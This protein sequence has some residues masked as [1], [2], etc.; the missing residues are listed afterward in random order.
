[1]DVSVI[2]VSYNTCDLLK[3]CICSILEKTKGVSFEIIVVDNH[4]SDESVKVITESF[5][6]VKIISLEENLG[7]G[8]AN[9]WGSYKSI[10]KYLFFLNPDTILL[11]DAISILVEFLSKNPEIAI[12][13]GNLYKEDMS[14]NG[15]YRMEMP[16]FFDEIKGVL[17]YNNNN[18]ECFNLSNQPKEVQYVCGADMMIKKKVFE[19]I[20]GFN[21]NFFMYCEEPFI[22][23]E[24]RKLGYKTYSCPKAKIIHKDGSSCK[25]NQFDKIT[26]F[27]SVESHLKFSRY[28]MGYFKYFILKMMHVLKSSIALIKALFINDSRR[29][30][31]WKKYLY[32]VLHS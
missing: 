6:E 28:Y 11:N 7:F 24:A 27:Y 32:V 18:C 26:R 13:G 22:S 15:S 10:G 23:N 17:N 21:P 2:I 3:K 29:I 16:S 20:G 25:N 8:R 12:V 9:N 4:S 19:E 14:F 30:R 31:Y 5:P 1:M